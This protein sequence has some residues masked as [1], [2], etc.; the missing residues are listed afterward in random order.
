MNDHEVSLSSLV[1]GESV[2]VLDFTAYYLPVSVQHNQML[3]ALHETY[4]GRGMKIYQ[5]CLDPDENFW[6]VCASR[7]PWTAVRDRDVLYDREGYVQ[8]SRPA[9]IYNVQDLPTVYVLGKDGSIE[10]RVTSDDELRRA[11]ARRL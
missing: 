10:E 2:V 11:V 5:V 8:Y 7:V 3:A 4:G 9:G 1:D 6:K